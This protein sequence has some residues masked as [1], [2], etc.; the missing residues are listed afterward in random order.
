M[1]QTKI[2]YNYEEEIGFY[3]FAKQKFDSVRVRPQKFKN[4]S[5]MTF[6]APDNCRSHLNNL[7]IRTIEVLTKMMTI[8][9][10]N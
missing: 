3:P 5:R 10:N 8:F 7:N 1:I 6:E 4:L 9:K 2:F